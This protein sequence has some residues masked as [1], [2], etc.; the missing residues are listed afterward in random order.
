MDNRIVIEAPE[1]AFGAY[2]AWATSTAAPAVVVLHELFGVNA[3]ERPAL[4]LPSDPFAQQDRDKPGAEA[5]RGVKA[6]AH[7]IFRRSGATVMGRLGVPDSIADCC[8]NHRPGK[9]TR[10]YLITSQITSQR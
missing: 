7:W 5:S 6:S 10:T 9:I 1:G 4:L 2:I 3:L 8:L